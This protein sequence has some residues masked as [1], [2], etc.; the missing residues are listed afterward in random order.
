MRRGAWSLKS[1][2]IRPRT[3][4]WADDMKKHCHRPCRK[5]LHIHDVVFSWPYTFARMAFLICL[6]LASSRL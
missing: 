6:I 1:E 4:L 3:P 5:S 2:D